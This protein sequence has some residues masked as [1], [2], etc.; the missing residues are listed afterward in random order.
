MKSVKRIFAAL[1]TAAF[2]ASCTA[3]TASARTIVLSGDRNRDGIITSDDALGV[4]RLSAGDGKTC[5]TEFVRCDVDGD[6]RIT[7]NDALLILRQSA[8]IKTIEQPSAESDYSVSDGVNDFSVQLLRESAK[9]GENDLVSPLSVYMALAMQTGGAAN[10]TLE[11]MNR[12]LSGGTKQLPMSD[13]DT[14]MHDYI[15]NINSGDILHTANSI[16][17]M[18]NPGLH[19]KQTF[20]DGIRQNYFAEVFQGAA[21]NATVDKINSWVN[22]NTNEMIPTILPPDSLS[23][24]TVSVLLNAVAFEATW[25]EQFEQ[26]DIRPKDFHNIDGTTSKD[27][28]LCGESDYFISD[29]HSVGF[30]KSYT[31]RWGWSDEQNQ[32]VDY[33]NYGF[34]AILPDEDIGVDGYL[35][36]MDDSTVKELVE[37]RS[38]RDADIELPKFKYDCTY[39][40]NKTL[41]NMGMPTAF[42]GLNAD[43]SNMAQH[44]DGNIFISS[45]IHKTFIDLDEHG[46]K[47]AAVT[48][49][50]D[51]INSEEPP[52]EKELIKLDRPFIYAIY[53][54]E[55]NV[56]VFLGIVKTL[57]TK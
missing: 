34:V 21:N 38:Y 39:S 55:N 2:A 17:V 53:D 8:G 33:E 37:S 54:M 42:S 31:G 11:E 27:D 57:P 12:I 48:A 5:N 20:L 43:F 51:E 45:V 23:E 36:Q 47:A 52:M 32:F 50:F 25:A 40:L 7:S 15:E 29:E 35:A 44:D 46:T 13:I 19:M 9:A 1:L 56:P 6:E 3:V 14:F 22:M 4:L 28:Y 41:S 10:E 49:I 24:D 16:F 26:T 18:D 30:I